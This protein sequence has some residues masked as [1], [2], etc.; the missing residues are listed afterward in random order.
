MK[1]KSGKSVRPWPGRG[2]EQVLR[3]QPRAGMTGNR[4][5][6]PGA[7]NHAWPETW[8]KSSHLKIL[9]GETG[10]GGSRVCLGRGQ[11]GRMARS[12]QAGPSSGSSNRCGRRAGRPLLLAVQSGRPRGQDAGSDDQAFLECGLFLG[13]TPSRGLQ[14]GWLYSLLFHLGQLK[15]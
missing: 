11:W 4:L 9:V 5:T 1:N 3:E 15:V 2:L 13:Q 12:C 6:E 8:W 14:V 10:V 7:N